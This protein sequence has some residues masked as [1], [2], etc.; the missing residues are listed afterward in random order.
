M[1]SVYIV[2]SMYSVYSV[3]LTT[4]KLSRV[5]VLIGYAIHQVRVTTKQPFE[6]WL[7]VAIL[8]VGHQ[9]IG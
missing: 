8:R 9:T 5:T 7:I 4:Y 6:G 2:Y 1:Y 3:Y